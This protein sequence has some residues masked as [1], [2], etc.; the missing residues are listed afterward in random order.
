MRRLNPRSGVRVGPGD[1]G[2]WPNVCELAP[3]ERVTVAETP[4]VRGCNNISRMTCDGELKLALE[5]LT[6]SIPIITST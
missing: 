4:G 3:R 2:E 5:A 6:D 1:R